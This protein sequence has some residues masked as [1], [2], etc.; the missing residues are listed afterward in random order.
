M[1]RSLLT[2]WSVIAVALLPLGSNA[3]TEDVH[4]LQPD[5]VFIADRALGKETYIYVKLAKT[6]TAPSPGTRNEGEFMQVADGQNKW[7]QFVWRTRLA[8]KEDLKLGQHFIAF[9]DHGVDGVYQAPTKK[10]SARGNKWWYAKITDLT[11]TYKGYV[12]VSGNYK[13][14]LNNLRIPMPFD[15]APMAMAPAPTPAEAPAPKAAPKPAAATP[16]A[17]PAPAPEPVAAAPAKKAAPA[18][19]EELTAEKVVEIGI[20]YMMSEYALDVVTYTKCGLDLAKK[21]EPANFELVKTEF[22]KVFPKDVRKKIDLELMGP[23]MVE[24]KRQLDERGIMKDIKAAEK[25]GALNCDK[26]NRKLIQWNMDAKK[27]WLE[28]KSRL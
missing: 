12:T 5:D 7:T 11:D 15:S 16:V 23:D 1:L 19:P 18:Q 13:V 24:L 2:R 10:E 26:G 14:G 4:F 27:R 8:T 20:E 22:L 21:K 17:A 28:I 25:A 3:A 6:I 9:H